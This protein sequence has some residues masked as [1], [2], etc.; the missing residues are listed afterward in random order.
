MTKPSA[1][2]LLMMSF[3]LETPDNWFKIEVLVDTAENGVEA[4][5]KLQE[6]LW[7]IILVDIKMPG[8]ERDGTS[9]TH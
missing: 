2:W 4:L 8:M 5:K 6:S 3:R 7:D 1:F 9:E